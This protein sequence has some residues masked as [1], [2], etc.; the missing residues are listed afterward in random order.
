[1]EE[2]IIENNFRNSI[3]KLFLNKSVAT[4]KEENGAK[5]KKKYYLVELG[6]A[7]RRP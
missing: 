3:L 4:E 2:I 7:F 1:M 5:N 6:L